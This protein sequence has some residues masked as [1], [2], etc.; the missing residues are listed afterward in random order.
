[1]EHMV[2]DR[3]VW[4]L[5]SNGLI[6]NYLC[7]FK[8]NRSTLDDLVRLES[9]IYISNAFIRKENAVAIFFD[10]EKSL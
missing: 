2:N 8:K 3:L 5:E 4:M 6:S 1:M 7:G 10:L 9:Y